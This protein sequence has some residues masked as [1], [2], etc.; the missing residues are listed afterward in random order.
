MVGVKLYVEGGGDSRPLHDACRKG[1]RKFLEKAGLKG[2]MPRIVACGSRKNAYDDYCTAI[3]NGEAAILLVDSEGPVSAALT[4]PWTHLKTRD[5]WDKP[6][7]AGNNDCHLMVQ[8]MEAWLL[9]DP[10]ALKEFYG[11]GFN[12]NALPKRT[13]IEGLTKPVMKSHLKRATESTTKGDYDKGA[14]SFEILERI[15]PKQVIVKS[16]WAKRFVESLLNTIVRP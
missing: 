14:H 13:D 12:E 3:K 10:V 2:R 15:D 1:F 6:A 5:N 16:P 11:Q 9:A 7:N 4:E 8:A